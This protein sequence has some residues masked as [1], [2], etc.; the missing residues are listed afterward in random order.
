MLR[1]AGLD[2]AIPGF[3]PLSHRQQSAQPRF[4]YWPPGEKALKAL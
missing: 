4:F 1:P 2:S 3:S